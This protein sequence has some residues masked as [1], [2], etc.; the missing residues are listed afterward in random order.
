MVGPDDA[1]EAAARRSWR[2]RRRIKR[3]FLGWCIISLLFAEVGASWFG[4][5]IARHAPMSMAD[6]KLI[7]ERAAAAVLLVSFAVLIVAMVLQF[8]ARGRLRGLE[9]AR[10]Q[11]LA[12]ATA[13]L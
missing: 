13:N 4:Y 10:L 8:K 1:A 3:V 9:N 5:Y 12:T 7:G 11:R 6:A 2:F